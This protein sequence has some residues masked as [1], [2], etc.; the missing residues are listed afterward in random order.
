MKFSFRL[1]ELLNHSPDPKKRPGTIKAICDYTGLDRHQVSSLLK[2]EAK[3]IPLTA[4]SQLC[5][6]LIKHGYADAGQLPGA[7]F[8]VEP[9]NFW[10]LLA[11]RRRI[12]MC[13]GVRADENWPEG[14]WVVASDT[15]L[16]GELLT[17]ISTLGGT[18]K[19]QRNHHPAPEPVMLN[20]MGEQIYDAPIP[21]PEDLFQTLVWAPG[22]ADNEEVHARAAEVYQNFHA[23]Q[24]DKALICLGSIRS[25]PVVEISMA[26]IFN[27]EPYISQ[28][29]VE[30]PSDRAVPI[31]LRHRE[32][33]VEHPESCSGGKRL[34]KTETPETPGFY[35]ETA[36]GSWKCAKWDETTY[37]PAYVLYA[38]HE[39]QGRLEM[40]LGGY[41]GR[42]T[43]LLA[44]TLSSRPEELWPPV[45]TTGGVQIG[46]YIVQYELKKQKKNRSVLT[47]DYSATTKVIPI[48]PEVIH[49]RIHG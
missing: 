12:E 17:G 34:S 6:F 26:S 16:Q 29:E 44:K 23:A 45:Y 28:D 11:R 7:L 33:N 4:L 49:R 25:N 24:G 32:K 38:Y 48:D 20:E 30:K 13:L 39:S 41:S 21:Q 27:C 2:N 15:I 36:D 19:Y 14:A 47:A 46:A 43:R 9:E 40:S 22:Q 31:Y 37:E 42:G 5:D 3:Y 35:Y 18:A 10:E 1:A 8:S